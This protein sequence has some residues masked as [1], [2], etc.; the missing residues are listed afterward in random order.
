MRFFDLRLPPPNW[1]NCTCPRQG[2]IPR[3]CRDVFS[4]LRLKAFT[5]IELLTVITLIG[6]LASLLFPGIRSARLAANKA[7]TRV[8]FNQWTTAIESFRSEYGYYPALHGS[9]LVN[10]AGQTGDP[11]TLHL[12]HDILAARRRDGSPLP[13]YAT[14]TNNQFPEVQNRRLVSFH[15]FG[16]ADFTAGGLLR[17]ACDNTAIAVLVDRNLDGVIKVGSDFTALPVVNGLSPGSSDF[18][19]A[20]V[21]AGVIFYSASPNASATNPEFIFSWK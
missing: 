9:N 5:L 17:D 11:A 19:T 16:D 18:P 2:R 14:T 1:A 10:P 13:V 20:G 12:F 6:I 15:S 4:Y 21:R 7:K 8:Q 3:N